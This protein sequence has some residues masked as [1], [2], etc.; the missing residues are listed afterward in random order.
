MRHTRVGDPPDEL[1]RV[2]AGSRGS[3]KS[4]SSS[5]NTGTVADT[6]DQV[7]ADK[8]DALTP[9]ETGNTGPATETAKETE[10]RTKEIKRT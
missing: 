1:V 4:I 10:T 6:S 2:A 8:K 3:P 9:K 7:V 5:A